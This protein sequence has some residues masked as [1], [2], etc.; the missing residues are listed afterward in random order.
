MNATQKM[1]TYN[2]LVEISNGD[3]MN[4][5]KITRSD[6]LSAVEHSKNANEKQRI[7]DAFEGE[8]VKRLNLGKKTPPD[9]PTHC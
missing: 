7:Y 5:I 3:L 6:L 8:R 2:E 1:P 4:K 9:K